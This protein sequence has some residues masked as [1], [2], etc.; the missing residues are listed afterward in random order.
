MSQ[1]LAYQKNIHREALA[2]YGDGTCACCGTSENLSLDHISGDGAEQREELFGDRR[3]GGYRF[4]LWLRRNGYPPGLQVLCRR[5]NHSKAKTGRCQLLH[6]G[7]EGFKRC[8]HPRHE[9]ENPLPLDRFYRN[10]DAP[11]GRLT[12][13][14]SCHQRDDPARRPRKGYRRGEQSIT[15]AVLTREN[16]LDCRQRVRNGEKQSALARE[17]GV[18][19]MTMSD[20]IR[21]VTWAWLE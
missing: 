13:C 8:S 15:R 7:P 18:S 9:G 20:V 3:I 16:V 19:P 21:R 17:Y 6:D 1:N 14:K 11:D 2:A 4:Y 12:R 10:P 5:C